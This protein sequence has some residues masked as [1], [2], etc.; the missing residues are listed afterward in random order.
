MN[1]SKPVS[2]IF[3]I[4]LI[5][6]VKLHTVLW[7]FTLL[8]AVRMLDE[9][10]KISFTFCVRLLYFPKKKEQP[11]YVFSEIFNSLSRTAIYFLMEVQYG[12][13]YFLLNI[14]RRDDHI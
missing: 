11:C 14:S 8:G 2:I 12:H 6:R 13:V 10:L 9:K 3:F 7:R 5:Y 4:L 1:S